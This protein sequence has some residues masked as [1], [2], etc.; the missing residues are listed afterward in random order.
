[1]STQFSWQQAE[2]LPELPSQTSDIVDGQYVIKCTEELVV[3]S[4]NAEVKAETWFQSPVRTVF[5]FM[6]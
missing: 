5:P 4:D 1:M 6:H 2:G 3:S